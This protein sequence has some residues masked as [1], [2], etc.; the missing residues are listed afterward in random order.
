MGNVWG[1]AII[2]DAVVALLLSPEDDLKAKK[3]IGL[4]FR[5]PKLPQFVFVSS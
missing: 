2:T 3:R 5:F 4:F 1:F